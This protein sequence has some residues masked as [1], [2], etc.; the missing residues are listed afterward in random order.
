MGSYSEIFSHLVC[1]NWFSDRE[2]SCSIR[3]VYLSQL[4]LGEPMLLKISLPTSLLWL[5]QSSV[6]RINY[7]T[8][9]KVWI[10]MFMELTPSHVPN[11]MVTWLGIWIF[12]KID[13]TH[14]NSAELTSFHA[15]MIVFSVGDVEHDESRALFISSLFL[16]QFPTISPSLHLFHNACYIQSQEG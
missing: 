10:F 9:L 3:N 2:M 8:W 7:V 11:T 1:I 5:A 15:E 14:M 12:M 6:Q 16:F 4:Y 13:P